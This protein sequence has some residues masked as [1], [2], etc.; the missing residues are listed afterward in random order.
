MTD[1]DAQLAEHLRLAQRRVA[2]LDVDDAA[3]ARAFQRLLAISDAA[4]RDTTRAAARLQRFCTDLDAGHVSA[5]GDPE[6]PAAQGL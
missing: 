1:D 6:P 2:A 4:K 5:A 3:K